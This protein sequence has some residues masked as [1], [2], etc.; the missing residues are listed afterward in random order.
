[1]LKLDGQEAL[2]L[3]AVGRR[4]CPRGRAAPP[5]RGR[6]CSPVARDS[7]Y[8]PVGESIS[9]SGTGSGGARHRRRPDLVPCR[10]PPRRRRP[11]QPR[12]SGTMHPLGARL[13]DAGQLRGVRAAAGVRG[14]HAGRQ[15]VELPAHKHAS[16]RTPSASSRRSTTTRS[17]PPRRARPVPV[18]P[19]DVDR[20][21]PA[22]RRARRGAYGRR[23]ARTGGGTDRSSRPRAPTCAPR[24]HRR[25]GR[26]P[27]VADQRPPG[28]DV[29]TRSVAD[30]PV[31]PPRAHAEGDPR[32]D[33]S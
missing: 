25:P 33:R 24:R 19:D 16:T 21:R 30:L 12:G 6:A 32:R 29:G 20:S 3:P 18:P 13:R 11:R 14:G 8:V 28:P 2:V 22:D 31:D 10:F 7:L 27:P 4:P 1:M 26:R 23:R 17:R 5:L 9:L 15:L